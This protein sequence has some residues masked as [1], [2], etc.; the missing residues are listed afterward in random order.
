MARNTEGER[1][2]EKIMRLT[3]FKRER[4]RERERESERERERENN[5]YRDTYL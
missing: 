4:E 1:V 5:G 3:E 2:W